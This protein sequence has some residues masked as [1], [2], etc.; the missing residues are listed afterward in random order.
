M[1]QYNI[2]NLKPNLQLNKLKSRIK[3]GTEVTLNLSSNLIKI[4]ILIIIDKTLFPH[5]LLLTNKQVSRLH[6]AFA[7]GSIV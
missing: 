1:T 3:N 7:Y 4:I 5:N 6:K 2:F